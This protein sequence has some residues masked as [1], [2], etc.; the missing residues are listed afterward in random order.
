MDKKIFLAVSLL[1]SSFTM[2]VFAK[3]IV[4]SKET[5]ASIE[6]PNSLAQNSSL[7]DRVSNLEKDHAQMMAEKKR[8]RESLESRIK[9]NQSDRRK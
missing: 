7:E 4:E 5:V 9:N 3:E 1:A 2:T 8:N 6:Q